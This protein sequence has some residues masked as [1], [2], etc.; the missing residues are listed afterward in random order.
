MLHAVILNV[1]PRSNDEIDRIL[2]AWLS[3]R[4]TQ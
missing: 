2:A 4:R 3:I 1:A